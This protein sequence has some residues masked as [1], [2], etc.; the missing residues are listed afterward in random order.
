MG[1]NLTN[2]NIANCLPEVSFPPGLIAAGKAELPALKR[3]IVAQGSW[4][5]LEGA[6]AGMVRDSQH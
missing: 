4:F 6:K 1:I 5:T 3:C 2:L